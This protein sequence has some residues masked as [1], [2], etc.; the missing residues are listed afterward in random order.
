MFTLLCHPDFE[1]IIKEE[2]GSYYKTKY[3]YLKKHGFFAKLKDTKISLLSESA[4]REGIIKSQQIV[5]EVTD[6]CN[7][8]CKYCALG[9]FYEGHDSRQNKNI[10]INDAIKLLQYIFSLKGGR[11]TDSF[12]IGFYGGEPLLNIDF[13]KS[14]V[15]AVA[16]INTYKIPVH[17]LM[18]TN[19]TLL[20]KN[21]DFLV[22]NSFRLLISL[23]GNEF[24]QS[25][26][27]F[28][29][30][31]NSFNRV[32]TN[33]DALQQKYPDYFK[34]QISFNAVLH[35]KNSVKSI[36]DFI[37]NR[38]G[39]APKIAQLSNKDIKKEKREEFL[40]MYHKKSDDF[41][42]NG[43]SFK[44]DFDILQFSLY[45]FMLN[46][47]N[48]YTPFV[49]TNMGELLLKEK[50]YFPTSTCLPFSKKIYHT[51]NNK[52]LPC[53]K[54]NYKYSFGKIENENVQLDVKNITAQYNHYYQKIREHCNK[55]YVNR[56]CGVCL[57][58]IDNIDDINPS[59]KYIYN[60]KKF[61]DS[62]TSMFSLIETNTDNYNAIRNTLIKY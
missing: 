5:F 9:D 50:R 40:K 23:D 8:Q 37:I 39:K 41:K 47:L 12:A 49:F 2:D 61:T 27:T 53:E 14:I 11:N 13:I 4:V 60:K 30:N 18:T 51:I 28:K 48:H 38:Y 42:M 33:I 24:N 16:K 7:L 36:Y 29:N 52:L 35:D 3:D 59:C 26:R 19:A 20:H 1:E 57:F 17:Y 15:D 21:I 62:L 44:S 55:C 58:S 10:N 45:K 43:E 46:F 56:F 31:T 6:K 32:I 25:Y 22:N 54:V 34:K